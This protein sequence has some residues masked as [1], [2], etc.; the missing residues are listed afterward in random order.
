[1]PKKR[2]TESMIFW[3]M[4]DKDGNSVHTVV[5]AF[6]FQC[7]ACSNCGARDWA[8]CYLNESGEVEFCDQCPED[9]IVH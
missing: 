3:T 9:K 1:M 2:K 5:D 4:N 6:N 8:E 7:S